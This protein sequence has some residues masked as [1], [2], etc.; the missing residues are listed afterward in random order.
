MAAGGGARGGRRGKAVSSLELARLCRVS[1][2]TVDRALHNR[3]RIDPATAERIL[4]AARRYGYAPNPAAREILTGRSAFVGAIVPTMNSIFFMH[5][6]EELRE[7]LRAEGLR[8]IISPAT[9][10][11]ETREI[12]A[13]FRARRLRG[14]AV[15][16]PEDHVGLGDLGA[17][18]APVVSLIN[19]CDSPAIPFVGP[20]EE[21]TGAD[22]VDY[23]VSRG[24]RRIL[25][26]SYPRRSW[27][28]R[29]REQGYARAMA[30]HGLEPRMVIEV[31]EN[32][33]LRELDSSH[34][35]ALFCH[36]DWL[37]LSAI[38]F[39][40]HRGLRVPGDVSVLGID[41]SPVFNLL[42]PGLT[43]MEY[44]ARDV[45]RRAV[46]LLL[47]GRGSGRAGRFSIV[48]RETVKRVGTEHC[49]A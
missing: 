2:G 23:L 46:G 49:P 45:A 47:T 43:T 29:A 18:G 13:D 11:A 24:H 44:P 41:N 7:A 35:T 34:P 37:A 36:N 31:T 33:F 5:I 39:L 27:A 48:E 42:Y 10:A 9:D 15:V 32:E 38:R 21:R 28:M 17:G 6:V 3:G 16:P 25:F 40:G 4:A 19:P 30:R 8:L 22:G 26:L 14:I 12:L 20:D 1:Q